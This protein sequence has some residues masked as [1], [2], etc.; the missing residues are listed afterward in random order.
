MSGLDAR[1]SRFARLFRAA[2]P[3][4]EWVERQRVRH[5]GAQL[6]S[7]NAAYGPANSARQPVPGQP[8]GI[9]AAA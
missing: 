6:R 9:F 3:N 2:K 7:M 8:V 4:D 1:P 5:V